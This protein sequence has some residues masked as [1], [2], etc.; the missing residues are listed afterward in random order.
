MLTITV[1]FLILF[2]ISNSRLPLWI[3]L[4][5][6]VS[7][8]VSLKLAILIDRAWMWIAKILG[9]IMPNILLSLIFFLFLFPI[10]LLQKLFSKK[11]PLQIRGKRDSTF[12][13]RTREFSKESF[14]KPW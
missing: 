3:A 2:L 10:S 7:G 12:L 5:T 14:E 8:L 11:D 13:Y 6:G 4:I 1:G 9:Y